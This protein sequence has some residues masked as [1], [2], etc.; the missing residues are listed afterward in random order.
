MVGGVPKG[1]IE[2]EV[3]LP[4]GSVLGNLMCNAGFAY[5]CLVRAVPVPVPAYQAIAVQPKPSHAP[6]TPHPPI[7]LPCSAIGSAAAG[8]VRSA[9]HTAWW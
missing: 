9:V 8:G 4:A 5:G 2:R 7:V 3:L 1:R 6:T